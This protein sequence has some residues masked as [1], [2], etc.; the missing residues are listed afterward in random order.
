[1]KRIIAQLALIV[2]ASLAAVSPSAKA[3]LIAYEGFDPTDGYVANVNVDTVSSGGFGW[4]GNWVDQPGG[5]GSEARTQSPGMTF[6]GLPT[7]G[8]L[9]MESQA[10]DIRR[11]V[12]ATP[13]GASDTTVWLSYLVQVSGYGTHTFALRDGTTSVLTMTAPN[14]S[15]YKLANTNTTAD[16]GINVGNRTGVI[17][18]VVVKVD[19]AAGNDTAQMWVFNSGA[20]PDKEASLPTAH[21]AVSD[22]DFQFEGIYLVGGY[23]GFY[24]DEIRFATTYAEVIGKTIPPKGTVLTI[25]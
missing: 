15:T 22:T 21:A 11:S 9:K 6:T 24:A 7:G 12:V 8:D 3:D 17:R 4:N 25:R 5:N 20:L 16:S 19:Y 1:M 23:G 10:Q 2:V 18:L 13:F 14:N